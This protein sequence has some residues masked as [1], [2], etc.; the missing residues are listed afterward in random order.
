VLRPARHARD[1]AVAVGD[2]VGATGWLRSRPVD[3][4]RTR[5][6]VD[7]VADRL[8]FLGHPAVPELAPNALL[9]AAYDDRCEFG[10]VS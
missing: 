2:H 9:E 10:E 5:H 8:D 6:H 3:D 7:V 4:G 1:R